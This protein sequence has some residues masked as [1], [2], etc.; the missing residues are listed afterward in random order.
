MVLG[1]LSVTKAHFD[2][3]VEALIQRLLHVEALLAQLQTEN[4]PAGVLEDAYDDTSND[5]NRITTSLID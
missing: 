1:F 4:T 3:K 2:S 5:E